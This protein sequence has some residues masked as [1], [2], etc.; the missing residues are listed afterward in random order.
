M[1][2]VGEGAIRNPQPSTRNPHPQ[3]STRAPQP[4]NLLS[5]GRKSANN[6]VTR[7]QRGNA[8]L[9]SVSLVSQKKEGMPEQIWPMKGMASSEATLWTAASNDRPE[10]VQRLLAAGAN[11]DEKSLHGETALHGAVR[12]GLDAIV[13]LLLGKGAGV[14]CTGNNMDTALH[15]AARGGHGAIV[16]RLLGR[17]AFVNA[18]NKHGDS[19]L[20]VAIR[21][22]HDGGAIFR[23]GRWRQ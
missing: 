8:V 7:A 5:S 19:A 2:S 1:R 12:G 6:R 15:L 21:G 22:G 14:D 4:T 16:A 10:E 18:K 11:I 3:P 13:E 23:Q 17:G 9:I 20:H